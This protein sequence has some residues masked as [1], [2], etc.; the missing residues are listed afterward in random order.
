MI[1]K[2]C[3]LDF[4]K[5]SNN[6]NYCSLKCSKEKAN[7][8]SKLYYLTNKDKINTRKRLNKYIGKC[9]SCGNEF[10]KSKISH[11]A[12]SHKC[13]SANWILLNKEKIRKAN[14]K[15]RLDNNY[16]RR[17][18]DDLFDGYVRNSLNHRGIKNP[19]NEMIEQKRLQL[20]ITRTIKSIKQKLK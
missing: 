17:Y 2:N 7:G 11:L 6:Q 5:K 4:A 19:T 1:C 8:K 14:S 13:S 16:N 12:C 3:G 15:W 18:V 10:I 20:K 9:I